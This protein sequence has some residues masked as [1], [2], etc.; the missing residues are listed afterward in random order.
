MWQRLEDENDGQNLLNKRRISYEG[1]LMEFLILM[2][3]CKK[4]EQK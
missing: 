3:Y 2:K 4:G 1:K